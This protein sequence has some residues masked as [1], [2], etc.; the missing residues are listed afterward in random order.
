MEPTIRATEVTAFGTEL[1][2]PASPAAVA[3][4]VAAMWERLPGFSSGGG[5]K[6]KKGRLF[7]SPIFKSCQYLPMA[8]PN[9]KPAGWGVWE[10]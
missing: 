8:E 3:A 4:N 2:E 10:M 1:P 9:R 5:G 6:K 7:L